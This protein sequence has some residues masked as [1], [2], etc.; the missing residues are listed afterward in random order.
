M[1][2]G[3]ER[4]DSEVAG[5]GGNAMSVEIKMPGLSQTSDEVLL[6]K[7]L[8]QEGDDIAKGDPLCEVEN[9][10]TVMPLESFVGGRVLEL[11]AKEN[12]MVA[13]GT[14]I[15]VIG[16]PGEVIAAAASESAP[17]GSNGPAARSDPAGSGKI[18][19]GVAGPNMERTMY[20]TRDSVANAS[21][22]VKELARKKGIDL[23]AIR[24]TGPNGR[25]VLADLEAASSDAEK[26]L[27][28]LK[29]PMP[30]R[31]ATIAR[32]LSRSKAEIP[33]FYLSMEIDAGRLISYR[34]SQGKNGRRKPSFYAPFMYAATRAL[35]RFPRLNVRYDD[36]SIIMN[37]GINV[38]V[39]I[40]SGEDL[41]VPVV[42]NT[43]GKGTMELDSEIGR[44]IAR[45]KEKN[46]E[47]GEQSEGS[48]TLSN[49]GMYPIDAFCAIIN[50]PQA[51]ILAFGRLRKTMRIDDEHSM[52]ICDVLTVTGSFDHRIAYGSEAAEFMACFKDIL[53]KELE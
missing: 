17:A 53:E 33:H 20:E 8:V 23:R 6:I 2:F 22:I 51:S 15:A 38:G 43:S 46:L 41:F 25:I 37:R 3:R 26:G 21:S 31:R 44:L 39:A 10:K 18:A 19:P 50:P 49:L 35:E 28:A 1:F 4:H 30:V 27:E 11:R 29:V 40:S 34:D 47:P 14:V 36:D 48:I 9:D 45:A 24:G 13:T 42:R 7:W 52:R 16:S 5:R 12:T 32:N